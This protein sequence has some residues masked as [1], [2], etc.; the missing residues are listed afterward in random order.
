MY[1]C[2]KKNMCVQKSFLIAYFGKKEK[3]KCRFG[4][5]LGLIDKAGSRFGKRFPSIGTSRFGGPYQ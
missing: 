4:C 5:G 1:V 2:V 3:K